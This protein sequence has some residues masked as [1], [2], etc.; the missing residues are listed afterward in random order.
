MIGDLG[1]DSFTLGS[2]MT[3]TVGAG[4]RLSGFITVESGGTLTVEAGGTLSVTNYNILGGASVVVN[5][6]LDFDMTNAPRP[7]NRF[8]IPKE[9]YCFGYDFIR[10]NATYTI[11]ID[12]ERLLSDHPVKNYIYAL[13]DTFSVLLN[14][15]TLLDVTGEVLGTLD[16]SNL[17]YPDNCPFKI[18]LD[19]TGDNYGLNYLPA[20]LKYSAPF[21][22]SEW[23]G[24][25][26]GT[27]VL[28]TLKEKPTKTAPPIWEKRIPVDD[29]KITVRIS[30]E[31]FSANEEKINNRLCYHVS[32]AYYC[33]SLSVFY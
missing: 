19:E 28:V 21:V 30:T 1:V 27:T 7:S 9:R 29:G 11:T 13:G 2:G 16:A 18:I 32:T 14:T 3:V 6:V 25:E 31:D 23:E 15:Y 22:S 24:L 20:P 26:D 8:H 12:I 17:V 33:R 4:G 5:G 10:G